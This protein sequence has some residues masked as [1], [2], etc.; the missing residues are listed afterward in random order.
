MMLVTVKFY[1]LIMDEYVER[2]DTYD[3]P[4]GTTVRSLL[5]LFFRNIMPAAENTIRS[6][7]MSK[8]WDSHVVLLNGNGISPETQSTAELK[9]GDK[10]LMYLPVDG[11]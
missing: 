10:V 11:G 5:E 8:V 7:W 6:D 4:H 3:I 9:E 1:G 2:T